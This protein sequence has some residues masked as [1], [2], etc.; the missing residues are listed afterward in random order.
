MEDIEELER[1]ILDFFRRLGLHSGKVANDELHDDSHA[2]VLAERI[3]VQLVVE[4]L[5]LLRRALDRR[6]LAAAGSVPDGAHGCV[7]QNEGA[8]C[9]D[10]DSRLH[11]DLINDAR[12]RLH[13]ELSFFVD[14]DKSG[15]EGLS[16]NAELVELQISIVD[17]IVAEFAADVTDLDTGQRLV[18]LK[19]TDLNNERLHTIIST[20]RNAAAKDDGMS[21]LY[22]QVARPEFGSFNRWRVDDEFA[23]VKV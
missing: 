11:H 15:E 8:A 20:V 2:E 18:S 23:G 21:S 3:H 1:A 16:R 14:R 10:G 4:E 17:A 6:E 13:L 19:I 9:G 22:T 7:V 5:A 12:V